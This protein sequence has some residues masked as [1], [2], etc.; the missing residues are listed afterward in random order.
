MDGF[1]GG[2]ILT[3]L[4]FIFIAV[5]YGLQFAARNDQNAA[6]Q[7]METRYGLKF[8]KSGLSRN[9]MLSGTYRSRAVTLRADDFGINN[10]YIVQ[11]SIILSL[12]NSSNRHYY[13]SRKSIDQIDDAAQIR[14]LDSIFSLVPRATLELGSHLVCTGERPY[15]LLKLDTDWQ[16]LLDRL[17]DLAEAVEQSNPASAR[18]VPHLG[19]A[20]KAI[21]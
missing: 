13:I 15:R 12:R 17:C 7:D 5:V 11:T 2:M 21:R 14:I 10:A 8:T 19:R 9:S 16:Y 6:W 4:C 3:V 20:P 1:A 18:T